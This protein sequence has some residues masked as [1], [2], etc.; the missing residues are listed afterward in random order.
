MNLNK[1]IILFERLK[2][3]T[4]ASEKKAII[5]IAVTELKSKNLSNSDIMSLFKIASLSSGRGPGDIL[6]KSETIDSWKSNE[7]DYLSLL[8][9]ALEESE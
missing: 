5:K 2:S 3:A 4:S 8:K 7:D 6:I 9:E 1:I